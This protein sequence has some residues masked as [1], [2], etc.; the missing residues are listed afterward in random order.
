MMQ[1]RLTALGFYAPQKIVTNQDMMSIVETNEEWILSRTG[2]KS[3]HYTAE[4]E[5]TSDMC[6][7]AARDL[8][9]RSGTSLADVDMVLVSTVSPDQPMPSMACQVQYRLGL[10]AGAMDI[11]AACAGFTYAVVVAQGLIASG[12]YRKILVIGADNLTRVTDFTDRS[13][14]VLFGDGAG[15][16]LIEAAEHGNLGRSVTGAYGEGGADLYISGFADV[17]NGVE[18]VKSGKIVQ[19]GR[20]VFKWAVTTVSEQIKVLAEKNGI[21]LDQIDWLVPHSANLR[22]LEALSN[23]TGI[24]MSRFLESI[25]D[26]GNTSSASI[27]LALGNGIEKGLLKSGDKVMLFG[28]GGGLAYAGVVIDW[29]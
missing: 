23:E 5:F 17:I 2:I 21:T 20:K 28:F 12:N 25:V 3:R 6:V 9:K 7:E 26:F 13:S 4:G 14:C 22:I 8:E 11:Y 29:P 10:T 19:N 24:P 15:A 18:V 1:S 27:P 16:V